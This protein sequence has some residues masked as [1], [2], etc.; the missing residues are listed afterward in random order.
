MGIVYLSFGESHDRR[1]C[2]VIDRG[3]GG[4][5]RKSWLFSRTEVHPDS[6]S[7]R[8]D[9]RHVGSGPHERRERGDIH[10]AVYVETNDPTANA[11]I[12]Y[13]RGNDGTLTQRQ[14]VLTGGLG[15]G[16]N[17]PFGFPITDSQ[18]AVVLKD[19][20]N[21]LFAVNAGNNSVSSF[22]VT[23]KGLRLVDVAW[24]GG[25]L[26]ISVTTEGNVLY[27]L[28]GLSGNIA[29]FHFDSHG[30]LTP[31]HGSRRSLATP[32]PNGVAAQIGLS[33]DGR[34]LTV[35]ERCFNDCPLN[36][37]GVIDTFKIG[38]T[39]FRSSRNGSASAGPIPFGF[40]YVDPQTLLVTNVGTTPTHN[41]EPPPAGDPTKLNGSTS[42]YDVSRSGR[43]MRRGL[44]P[45][46]GVPPAGS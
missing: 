21:L 28:N 4:A 7:C 23:S 5:F 32:G 29:G 42:S 18:G 12:V 24:S 11:I 30:E 15:S 31:I 35:T 10:N 27:A 16:A 20:G 8:R 14:S 37:Q 43:C 19:D 34:V 9:S 1:P 22:R 2:G 41:G 26:P 6:G 46:A 39:T 38:P 3:F 33:P 44:W 13:Q 17:Q 36:P 40:A 45:P 25:K